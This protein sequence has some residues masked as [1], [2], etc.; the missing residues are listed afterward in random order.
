MVNFLIGMIV[1]AFALWV[2][3][4]IVPGIHLSE[5]FSSVLFVALIF[6]FFNSIIGP[7][8]QFFSLPLTVLT[9]GLAALLINVAMLSITGAVS[10]NLSIDNFSSSLLGS[11][12]ITFVSTLLNWFLY[13]V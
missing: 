6:G 13:R 7:I 1:N 9:F 5:K 4:A 8:L 2:A 11:I 12:I 10:S 3:A